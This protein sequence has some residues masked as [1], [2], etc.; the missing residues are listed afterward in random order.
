MD[1][2]G[3]VYLGHS[4]AHYQENKILFFDSFYINNNLLS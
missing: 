1:S 3:Y 2:N 4:N